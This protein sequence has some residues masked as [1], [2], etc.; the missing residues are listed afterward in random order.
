[1]M[2]RGWSIRPSVDSL[3]LHT[4]NHSLLTIPRLLLNAQLHTLTLTVT[5]LHSYDGYALIAN[6]PRCGRTHSHLVWASLAFRH[7]HSYTESPDMWSNTLSPSM[8]KQ[9]QLSVPNCCPRSLRPLW[10]I[11]NAFRSSGCH[12]VLESAN[13]RQK[14]QHCL[15]TFTVPDDSECRASHCY[16]PLAGRIGQPKRNSR[17]RHDVQTCLLCSNGTSDLVLVLGSL[18]Q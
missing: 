7:S 3:M 13:W 15:S 14:F 10:F 2:W 12:R 16:G 6:P 11:L 17:I 4:L 8:D 1:M 9:G 18:L 5:L